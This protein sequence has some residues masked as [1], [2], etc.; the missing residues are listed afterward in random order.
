[1][2]WECPNC[3]ESNSSDY[4]NCICG[5]DVITKEVREG[6]L[7]AISKQPPLLKYGRVF[8]VIGVVNS[9]VAFATDTSVPVGAGAYRVNNLGLMN[10]QH[11]YLTISLVIAALGI[12]MLIVHYAQGSHSDP[13]DTKTCPFCAETIKKEAIFCRH[14]QKDLATE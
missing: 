14:C 13:E 11:N 12:L 4:T 8:V 9:I 10:E 5:Y 6:R 7:G 3:K 1:M 2:N